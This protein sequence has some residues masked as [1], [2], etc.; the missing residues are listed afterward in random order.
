MENENRG[1]KHSLG[2]LQEDS[3]IPFVSSP[4]L[5]V[6]KAYSRIVNIAYFFKS[7][8]DID[9]YT[10]HDEDVNSS[11]VTNTATMKSW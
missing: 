10:V 9:T 7:S 11:I 6:A 2:C 1:W 3:D 5:C 8:V 4:K